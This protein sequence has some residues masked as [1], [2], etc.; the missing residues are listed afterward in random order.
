ML[1]RHGSQQRK[2]HHHAQGDNNQRQALLSPGALLSAKQNQRKCQPT[3]KGGAQKCQ[4]KGSISCTAIRVAGSEPL[5]ITTPIRPLNQP[6]LP[7][8]RVS[9]TSFVT[10]LD[11]SK[12]GHY[13]SD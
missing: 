6:D 4:K 10:T 12:L 3:G 2:T 9:L 1:K 5:K 8:G 11:L 13:F 7:P